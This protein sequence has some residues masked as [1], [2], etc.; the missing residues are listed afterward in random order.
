[1]MEILKNLF[2]NYFNFSGKLGR[3]EFKVY[4]AIDSLLEI[5]ALLLYA[6][7]NLDNR[8]VLN[9]FYVNIIILLKLY[10]C[11]LQLQR[12]CEI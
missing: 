2:F 8:N 11:K 5:I 6:N 9:F 12:D 1:M 7:I 4:F 3:N 10:L